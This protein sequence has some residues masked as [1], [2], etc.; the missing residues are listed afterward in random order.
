M[1][2]LAAR[3]IHAGYRLLTGHFREGPAYGMVRPEGTSD[4]LLI[5]T[6]AGRGRIGLADGGHRLVG[7]GELI[8]FRPGT[9]QDYRTDRATGRWELQWAHCIP[10][11]GWLDLLDW[12]E[13]APGVLHLRLAEPATAERVRAALADMVEDGRGTS[14]LAQRL[15]QNGLERALLACQRALPGEG[16]RRDPRVRACLDLLS[17]TAGRPPGVAVLARQVGLSPSRL[18]HLFQEA[19]GMGIVQWR[20]QRRI[21]A[22]CELL[23]STGHSVAAVAQ[24]VGFPTQAA[25]ANRFRQLVGR[26]PRA[27]RLDTGRRWPKASL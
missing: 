9:R 5:H 23:E 17:R 26:S 7:P 21:Q 15:T 2:R 19:V 6:V 8:L 18:G 25:F 27:W 14:L 10:A 24:A 12:P 11:D 20:D 4:W 13:I 1:P 3:D 22:A 16:I